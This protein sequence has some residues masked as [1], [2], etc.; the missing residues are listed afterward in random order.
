MFYALVE[1]ISDAFIQAFVQM[2]AMSVIAKLI[3]PSI[4]SA[5]FA[6]FTGLGNLNTYFLAKILGNLFNLY[7]KVTKEDLTN[8]WKLH[9]I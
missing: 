3:P 2:P 8:L 7:F 6:F 5:L 4:E 9:V 1:L